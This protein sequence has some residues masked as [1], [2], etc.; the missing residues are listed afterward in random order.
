MR[1]GEGISITFSK[2]ISSDEN[3]DI[4]IGTLIIFIA[5]LLIAGVTASVLIQTMNNMQ[6]QAVK[7]SEETL[8]DVSSGLEVTHVSGWVYSTK[9][10][11]LAIFINPT[12]SSGGID[13]TY[14]YISLSDSNKTYI[15]NYTRACFSST[16]SNSLFTTVNS[17]KLTNRTYGI[18]VIRDID[19]SCTQTLPIINERDLV[20]LMVNTTKCFSGITTNTAVFGQVIPEVGMSGVIGFNTPSSYVDRIIDVQ[21]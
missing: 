13:L 2:A 4:G 12:S 10:G 15:L 3:A 11:K 7:T 21:P 16:V 8:R 20:V 14:T 1:E 6:Q 17:S 18:I 9:I 5:M 19:G